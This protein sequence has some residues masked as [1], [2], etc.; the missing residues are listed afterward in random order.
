[1]P[2]AFPFLKVCLVLRP[3]GLG[4]PHLSHQSVCLLVYMR[5]L[6][7]WLMLKLGEQ[8]QGQGQTHPSPASLPSRPE[9]PT[10][11]PGPDSHVRSVHWIQWKLALDSQ[12]RSGGHLKLLYSR[13]RS[14]PKRTLRRL[15]GAQLPQCRD[16]DPKAQKG[17]G[18]AQHHIACWRQELAP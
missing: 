15:Q 2:S 9:G 13:N 3:A 8:R 12:A 5:H 16:K 1:M 14:R 10:T 11:V 7:P 6:L 18:A 17:Q 4:V